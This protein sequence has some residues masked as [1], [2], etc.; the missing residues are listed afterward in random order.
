[1]ADETLKDDLARRYLLGRL[2]EAEQDELEQRLIESAEVQERI[3]VVESELVEDYVAGRLASPDR[4]SFERR[5]LTHAEG[6][7][8]VD[9]AR[10][11]RRRMAGGVPVR[12]RAWL[13]P[14]HAVA[15]SLL[16]A[17]L[18]GVLSWRELA[19]QEEEIVAV[20]GR[21]R[22]LAEPRR[23]AEA[24]LEEIPTETPAATPTPLPKPSFVLTPGVLRDA[25]S[26]LQT[27]AASGPMRL[28]LAWPVE[29]GLTYSAVI[30]TP[31]QLEI[32]SAEKLPVR[33]RG[34]TTFLVCRVPSLQPGDYILRL[35]ARQ[36]QGEWESVADYTFRVTL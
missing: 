11:L 34:N 17:S 25:A 2:G 13:R 4:E 9:V 23:D 26:G 1:M 27:V 20:R 28:E 24:R 31:D 30:Q 10:L 15:A 14:W 32:W 6:V 7:R 36:G 29:P 18:A 33:T 3:A 5:Y 8:K 12:R 22:E 35:H 19:L 21:E 16:V